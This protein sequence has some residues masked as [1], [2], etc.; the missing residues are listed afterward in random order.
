MEK[1]VQYAVVLLKIVRGKTP[2]VV[3]V[4]Q[5]HRVAKRLSKCR[6]NSH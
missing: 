4:R 2:T 3:A 6:E 5:G 1:K